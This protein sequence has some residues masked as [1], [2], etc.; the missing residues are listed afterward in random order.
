MSTNT[1]ETARANVRWAVESPS[2]AMRLRDRIYLAWLAF[3]GR[4]DHPRWLRERD[5]AW[6]EID[7]FRRAANVRLGEFL[8]PD[9]TISLIEN[10]LR[11][12]S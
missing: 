1:R 2:H 8:G 10:R 9:A 5:E 11:E 4:T 7:R 12:D 3:F 6:A